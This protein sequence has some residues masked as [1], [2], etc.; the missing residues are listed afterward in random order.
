MDMEDPDD[1]T[2][3]IESSEPAPTD[4][5]EDFSNDTKAL[6]WVIDALDII[7]KDEPGGT[8]KAWND[9]RSDFDGRSFKEVWANG[10][11]ED[12][13][14]IIQIVNSLI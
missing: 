9:P 10:T 14:R 1:W 11:V 7:Y 13:T 12:K 2:P 8:E 3:S 5:Y 4:K 6:E